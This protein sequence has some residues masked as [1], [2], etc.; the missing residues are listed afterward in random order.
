MDSLRVF[1][2]K[3]KKHTYLMYII[4]VPIPNTSRKM[5]S[6]LQRT[7]IGTYT[8]LYLCIMCVVLQQCL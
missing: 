2:L 6:R 7:H 5:A 8:Y 4:E 1:I 3:K